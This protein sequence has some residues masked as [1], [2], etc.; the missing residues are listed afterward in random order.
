MKYRIMDKKTETFDHP[1]LAMINSN[2]QEEPET[3]LWEFEDGSDV[4]NRIAKPKA[5]LHQLQVFAIRCAL[6]VCTEQFFVDWANRWLNTGEFRRN[7][8]LD[9]KSYYAATNSAL[10][11]VHAV[12]DGDCLPLAWAFAV[13]ANP[14]L[15]YVAIL[16]RVLEEEE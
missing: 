3:E 2:M 7:V 5:T 14:D 4:A 11:A 16:E 6:E 9:F 12:L 10:Y 1:V 15:D 8:L 13:Q